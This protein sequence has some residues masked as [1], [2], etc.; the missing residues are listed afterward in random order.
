M[1]LK[2]QKRAA[3]SGKPG[4]KP[5][6]AAGGYQKSVEKRKAIMDAA[7]KALARHGYAGAKLSD[8]AE[9]VGIYAGSIYYY[10]PSREDLVK[11]VMLTALERMSAHFG[12]ALEDKQPGRSA[13]DRLEAFIRLVLA[14]RTSAKDDYLRAY[15]RNYNQ[16]PA[17]IR[18][19]LSARR[20]EVRRA[21]E[22]LVGEAQAAGRIPA[23]VDAG[24]AALFVVGAA[25]W[26]G[27]WYEP[28]GPNTP[29][30]I[31]D[32]F[33]ALILRGLLGSPDPPPQ[34]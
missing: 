2:P 25:N 23:S 24:L 34:A 10:F 11:D 8:I 6:D 18:K 4:R 13:L 17:S 27:M 28:G 16:V 33:V 1:S 30:Q 20:H 12:E 32:T 3:S 22:R 19:E 31:S 29:K 7:A 15:T 9:D 26:V 14:R 5:S 21:V